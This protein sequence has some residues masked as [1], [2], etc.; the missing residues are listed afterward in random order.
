[1]P[2]H[3]LGTPA[4]KLKVALALRNNFGG[5]TSWPAQDVELQCGAWQGRAPRPEERGPGPAVTLNFS[6]KRRN[7]LKKQG[8][9]ILLRHSNANVGHNRATNFQAKLPPWQ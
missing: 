6:R 2:A 1:M 8:S 9:D 3:K 7:R 4:M 5:K